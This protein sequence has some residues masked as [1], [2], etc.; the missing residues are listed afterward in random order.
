LYDSLQSCTLAH[1]KAGFVD[2]RCM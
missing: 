2:C 1:T